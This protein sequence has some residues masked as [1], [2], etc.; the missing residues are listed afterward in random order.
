MQTYK[1]KPD[2]LE[3]IVTNNFL[4]KLSIRR[5]E[6]SFGES[7]DEYCY[8][9]DVLI[10]EIS[11][12]AEQAKA[13]YEGLKTHYKGRVVIILTPMISKNDY[14]L[15]PEYDDFNSVLTSLLNISD[16]YVFICEADCEQNEV[17]ERPNLEKVLAQ[18]QG[19]CKGEHY[20]CPTFIQRAEM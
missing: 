19:F 20:D 13:Y 12:N 7:N 5:I 9:N 14:I 2:V 15:C 18:L 1:N 17:E 10:G 16:D 8:F 4:D 11:G 3:L 6:Y